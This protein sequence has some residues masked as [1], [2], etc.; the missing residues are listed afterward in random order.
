MLWLLIGYMLLFI[1]RPFEVWPSLA[2]YRIELLYMLATG[3][4]W[5]V[6][7]GKTWIANRLHVAFFAFAAVVVLCWMVSPWSSHGELTVENYLK[8]LVFY[9]LLVTVVHDERSLR[10]VVLAY[11]VIMFVYMGHSL[12]EYLNGRHVFRMGIARM[13]GVDSSFGDP[14]T[15]GGTLVYALPF[16]VPFWKCAPSR[17]LRWFLAG[18]VVLS[19]VCVA[20]TGSRSSF[21]GLLFLSLVMILRARRRGRLLVLAVLLAPLLWAALPP[22]L[23]NRF[24]TIINPAVGPANAQASAQGR[25][26]G[27]MV[28]LRLWEENPLT[29]CGPGAW[30]PASG[31]TV[32]S[33]NLYGQVLGETGTLG[34][35]AFGGILLGL[36]ANLR[37]VKQVSRLR[38]EWAGDFP[39]ELARAVGLAVLLLLFLGNFGHNLF[40]YTWLWYGGFLIIAR[41]CIE[42]RLQAAPVALRPRPA[43]G[44]PW[45]V[46][47]PG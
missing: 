21:V 46:P 28:G 14:N 4:V 25:L 37:R 10:R 40:R 18:Y 9:V 1:H 31:R 30:R 36:W 22:S 8:L 12:W 19:V 34:A 41:H 39:F 35:L 24:E 11:L 13:V 29:G 20:L 7:S 38:P 45:L 23:Q 15:F 43:V 16:V 2:P 27:L 44:A 6:A 17:R 42:Q 5:L 32:E 26:D 47:V 33:H 3:P